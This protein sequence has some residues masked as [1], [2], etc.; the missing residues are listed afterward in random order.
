MDETFEFSAGLGNTQAIIGQLNA[1]LAANGQEI[2]DLAKTTVAATQCG[3]DYRRTVKGMTKDGQEFSAEVSAS[4]DA[5]KVYSLTLKQ[6]TDR[7][8]EAAAM[9]KK[10][11]KAQKDLDAAEE[12]REKRIKRALDTVQKEILRGKKEELALDIQQA[13]VEADLDAEASK[14]RLERM[15]QIWQKKKESLA[16]DIKEVEYAKALEA[17]AAKKKAT[18]DRLDRAKFATGAA[19]GAFGTAVGGRDLASLRPDQLIR[20]QAQVQSLET[21]L[22]N[23]KLTAVELDQIIKNFNAGGLPIVGGAAGKVDR[24]LRSMDTTLNKTF[25]DLKVGGQKLAITWETVAQVFQVGSIFSAMAQVKDLIRRSID[26]F[27]EYEKQI[28]LI[29]TISEDAT[30]TTKQWENALRRTSDQF[31]IPL[32]DAAGAAYEAISNQIA[33]GTEATIYLGAASKF[34]KVTGASLMESQNAGASVLN[35]YGIS[36]GNAEEVF[37]KL[38]KTIDLGRVNVEQLNTSLGNQLAVASQLGISYEEILSAVTVIT[39]Q[40][41]GADVALTNLGA[42]MTKLLKPTKALSATLKELGYSSGFEAIQKGGGLLGVLQLLNREIEKGGVGALANELKDVRAIRGALQ[43]ATDQ[44]LARFEKNLKLIMGSTKQFEDAFTQTTQNLGQKWTD[45]TN[46]I[47][48]ITRVDIGGT[49]IKL[50]YQL[51][52]SAINGENAMKILADQFKITA[53]VIRTVAAPFSLFSAVMGKYEKDNKNTAAGVKMLSYLIYGS[54]AA[55]ALQT[56]M[57][58]AYSATLVN[59]TRYLWANVQAM[60]AS[61]YANQAGFIGPKLPGVAGGGAAVGGSFAASVGPTVAIIAGIALLDQVVQAYDR[62]QDAVGAFREQVANTA[63]KGTKDLQDMIQSGLKPFGEQLDKMTANANAL[64][65]NIEQKFQPVFEKTLGKM[66]SDFEDLPFVFGTVQ[67]AFEKAFDVDDRIK[68]LLDDLKDSVKA[69][70]KLKE[71]FS[72]LNIKK[73]LLDKDDLVAAISLAD[74]FG[75]AAKDAFADENWEKFRRFSDE[76]LSTWKDIGKTVESLQATTDDKL[77]RVREKILGSNLSVPSAQAEISK[78][79]AAAEADIKGN[80]FDLAEKKYESIARIIDKIQGAEKK[81]NDGASPLASQ[82]DM[83]NAKDMEALFTKQKVFLDSVQ[84]QTKSITDLVAERVK[85][86]EKINLILQER[87]DQAQKEK[88]KQAEAQKV[89]ADQTQA[90]ELLK[91]KAADY[92][93]LILDADQ[94]IKNNISLAY[95]ARNGTVGAQIIGRPLNWLM[96]TDAYANAQKAYS[97]GD[98]GL[99]LTILQDELKIVK[100]MAADLKDTPAGKRYAE[101]ETALTAAIKGLEERQKLEVEMRRT[102]GDQS[103]ATVE[104]DKMFSKLAQEPLEKQLSALDRIKVAVDGVKEAIQAGRIPNIPKFAEGG[105]MRGTA[106]DT[107]LALLENEEFIMPKGPSVQFRPMLESMRRGTFNPSTSSS[108][109]THVGDIYVTTPAMDARGMTK[110]IGRQLRRQIQL[111]NLKLGK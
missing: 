71:E 1:L 95:G 68:E 79:R 38:F 81:L 47:A 14:K 46:R 50:F 59:N 80:R 86:E 105:V 108:S 73:N 96:G 94:S 49:A 85:N 22:R 58:Q 91:K 52:E 69:T 48:N 72:Q 36:A 110:D 30:V 89:V 53:S 39:I 7:L 87:I 83:Q 29:R 100:D 31:N 84:V 12:K 103:K 37:A 21:V 25:N 55:Y 64:E 102:T 2:D 93:K 70:Q 45:T 5:F 28:G 57:V 51:G 26:D 61:N 4:T 76:Q 99:A 34:A 106:G 88:D 15:K 13:K 66:K 42:L 6:V 98:T 75:K 20:V 56:K 32:L 24:A 104:L 40:G 10:L 17:I 27:I 54:I 35:A 62:A 78:L 74:A 92:Q 23:S 8:A 107:N 67:A 60:R 82:L 43:S 77:M 109:V 9:A 111:G 3:E 18:D 41:V 97:S 33:R 101:G 63:E 11:D 90:I 65:Q 44:N 16:L 19:R